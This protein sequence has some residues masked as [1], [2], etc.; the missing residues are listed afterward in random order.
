MILLEGVQESFIPS[1]NHTLKFQLHGK[2][3]TST[4]KRSSLLE[5]ANILADENMMVEAV[6]S[7]GDMLFFF[8]C[9]I[10]IWAHGH[11]RAFLACL[12]VCIVLSLSMKLH[13]GFGGLENL[14][15]IR[16]CQD[17]P[18]RCGGCEAKVS[19]RNE[20]SP[21]NG[22]NKQRLA[23]ACSLTGS[24]KSWFSRVFSSSSSYKHSGTVRCSVPRVV[25]AAACQ[26][27]VTSCVL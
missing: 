20:L 11:Y 5:E 26:N 25:D 18:R 16:D 17:N 15:W 22:P 7:Y 12:T 1:G 3:R 14:R 4:L 24:A 2:K 23:D 6:C 10:Y 13:K 8:W 27:W 9:V 19:P 21:A